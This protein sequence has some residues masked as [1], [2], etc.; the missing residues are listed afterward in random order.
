M[1][2]RRCAFMQICSV[3]TLLLVLFANG[4]Q[5]LAEGPGQ[6][7]AEPFDVLIRG[8]TLYDGS[9]SPPVK[10]DLAI[11]GDKVIAVGNLSGAAAKTVIDAKG[12]AVSPGFIN[13]LSWSTES[14]LA[15]GRS[16]G[17]IRQGVTTQIMGEGWSMGPLND[18]IKRRMK[19]E[20]TDIRYDIEWTTL[21][22]YLRWLA[23]TKVSQNVASFIGA[24]TIREYVVGLEDRKATPAELAQMHA[25]VERE[26]KD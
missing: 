21:A 24:T 10:G 14:L 25:L 26:M 16:Q 18:A 2:F 4:S 13:M 22:D 23:R 5:G 11:R 12:L 19:A 20:Q 6:A 7:A 1:P 3:V 17:E 9:G 8:G 15:D